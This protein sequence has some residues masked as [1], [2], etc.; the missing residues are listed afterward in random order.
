MIKFNSNQEII[1]KRC[2]IDELVFSNMIYNNGFEPTY[3]YYKKDDTIIIRVESPGNCSI[4]C[5]KENYKEY[6]II[7]IVGE[8]RKDKEPINIEDNIFYNRK[9]GE[10]AIDI[11][12]N[13]NEYLISN[14]KP[15]ME[16]KKGI[17]MFSFKLEKENTYILYSDF[18]D[19]I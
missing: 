4:N 19:E 5:Y 13:H 14:E 2:L 3:N 1:L 15:I 9:F 18:S 8:K 11:P 10:F 6:V 7:R 16:E 17:I 12:F